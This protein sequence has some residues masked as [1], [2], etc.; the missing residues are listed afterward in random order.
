MEHNLYA[1][2]GVSEANPY[3]SPAADPAPDFELVLGVGAWRHRSLL[4]LHEEAQLPPVCVKTGRPATS[5]HTSD[6]RWSHLLRWPRE[7]VQV[8]VPLSDRAAFYLG[9]VRPIV[10]AAAIVAAVVCAAS[11]VLANVLEL[12]AVVIFAWLCGVVA[13]VLFAWWLT[14]AQPLWVVKR[15]RKYYWLS[16]A[17]QKFL[18]HLPG[19]PLP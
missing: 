11:I 16:G 2:S 7:Y 6:I 10:L 15:R 18:A 8:A 17:N 1:P 9:P 12:A 13:S 4:V 19:W 3:A 14:L 5:Y